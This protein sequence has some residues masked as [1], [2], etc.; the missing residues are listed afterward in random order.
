[1]E[2]QRGARV[3]DRFGP[4][5][6]NNPTSCVLVYYDQLSFGVHLPHLLY[7]REGRVTRKI[8]V[9]YINDPDLDSTFTCLIYNIYLLMHPRSR[10]M[11]PG[12]IH[13]VGSVITGPLSCYP[14]PLGLVPMVTNLVSSLLSA[15][16]VNSPPVILIHH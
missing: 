6:D 14:S 13:Q 3:L 16:K 4:P 8:R 10:A 2:T 11:I 5:E 7:P 1:M 12:F 15:W 9:S